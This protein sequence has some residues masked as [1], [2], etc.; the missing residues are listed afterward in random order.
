MSQEDG[1]R[2]DSK[3]ISKQ[4]VKMRTK[5]YTSIKEEMNIKGREIIEEYQGLLNK[6]LIAIPKP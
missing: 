2:E 3:S 4:G 1:K 5:A 6:G